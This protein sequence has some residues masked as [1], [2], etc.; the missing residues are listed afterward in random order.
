MIR[1]AMTD[2]AKQDAWRSFGTEPVRY[3]HPVRFAESLGL[4]VSLELAARLRAEPRLQERLS[5]Q[6][7]GHAAL[8]P[9]ADD[10]PADP[11]D[12]TIALLS[13]TELEKLVRIAGA[14]VWAHQLARYVRREEVAELREHLGE[15]V[16]RFA[17]AHRDLSLRRDHVA[18][19]GAQWVALQEDGWRCFRAWCDAQPPAIGRRALLKCDP[20]RTAEPLPEDLQRAGP[21]ILRCA[22][23]RNGA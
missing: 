1:N 3:V 19:R 8:P 2:P 16:L 14:I 7:V 5:A 10:E 21:Q 18:D 17:L 11:R 13:S 23:E 15:D 20:A 12:R 9:W 4:G 22:A 6:L